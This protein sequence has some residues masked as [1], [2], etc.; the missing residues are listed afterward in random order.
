MKK[1]KVFVMAYMVLGLLLFGL[2]NTPQAQSTTLKLAHMVSTSAHYHIGS[3]ELAR[4]IQERTKG[5]I[6]IEIFPAGQLGKGERELVEGL[7]IGTIDLVVTS[8]GPMGGFV[9]QMLVVDLPFLFRD[10]S[11]VDKVLDGPIGEGLLNELPKV[12]IKGIAF[13][14]NG[15]RNLT[16]NRRPV[17]RPEDVKGLKLRTMENEV[18]MEAFRNL[19]ADPTPMAWGEVYTA[20][21]QGVID[22]Q[23]NPIGIIRTH[24][25]YE[26]NKHLALT[27]HVYSPALLL[28]NEKKFKGLATDFQKILIEAGKEAARFERKFNRDSEAK[29]LEE[30]RGF[31]MQITTPDKRAFQK[32][33]EPT[34]KKYEARFGKDLIDKIIETK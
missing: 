30:L 19:G 28:I 32:A 5:A 13:W 20:L 34:Y 8:T 24:K 31:G 3:L 14:E 1:L 25:I 9:P 2:S 18:H 29:W 16:N 12:G 27:G 4:L 11:H 15:F 33:T 26:V 7:Q 21:Q 6:K 10:N 23:E 22:G 17:N